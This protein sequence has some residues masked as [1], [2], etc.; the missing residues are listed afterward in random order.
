VEKHRLREEDLP[1]KRVCPRCGE[2]RRL[3]KL[4]SL[5]VVDGVPAVPYRCKNCETL[6]LVRSPFKTWWA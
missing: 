5:A 6:F 3:K 1:D 2:Y 4:F